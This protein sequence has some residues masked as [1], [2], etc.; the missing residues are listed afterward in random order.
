MRRTWPASG[1]ALWSLGSLG[2]TRAMTVTSPA[3]AAGTSGRVRAVAPTGTQPRLTSS[4]GPSSVTSG[5]RT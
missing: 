1:A 3:G 5:V 2:R 4:A